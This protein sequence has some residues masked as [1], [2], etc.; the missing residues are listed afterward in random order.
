M[1]K[2]KGT[3]P[4]SG[5][6]GEPRRSG[7]NQRSA[8]ETGGARKSRKKAVPKG[9]CKDPPEL[10][11]CLNAQADVPCKDQESLDRDSAAALEHHQPMVGNLPTHPNA[12]AQLQR[13]D[14]ELLSKSPPRAG[15]PT[16]IRAAAAV[17][18]TPESEQC[19][20]IRPN[21]SAF[22]TPPKKILVKSKDDDITDISPYDHKMPPPSLQLSVDMISYAQ[23]AIDGHKSKYNKQEHL[24]ENN[25]ND[26]NDESSEFDD[27]DRDGDYKQ[28]DSSG[29][30]NNLNLA[31]RKPG[32]PNSLFNYSD[33]EFDHLLDNKDLDE[34]VKRIEYAN[35]RKRESLEH[36]KGTLLKGGPQEPSYEGVTAAKERTAMEEY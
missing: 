26:N 24:M 28:R 22:H 3:H 32:V 19:Y 30:D 13:K 27:D 12:Q 18:K 9:Q 20:P 21:C 5:S 25:G 29:D 1:A 2:I 4:Y 8:D 17:S 10:H 11:A 7:R 16:L 33:N 34:D 23:L 31:V 14:Q 36:R 6:P 35:L 15:M